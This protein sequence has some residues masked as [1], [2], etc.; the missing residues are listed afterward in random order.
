L[1]WR[2]AVVEGQILG[3]TNGIDSSDSKGVGSC[4]CYTLKPSRE[5]TSTF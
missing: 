5:E 2:S 3:S 4:P 1:L